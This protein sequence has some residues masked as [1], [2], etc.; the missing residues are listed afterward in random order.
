MWKRLQIPRKTH[1][2]LHN[3][4]EHPLAH[5]SLNWLLR[6][7]HE[8]QEEIETILRQIKYQTDFLFS[9]TAKSRKPKMAMQASTF[10]STSGSSTSSVNFRKLAHIENNQAINREDKF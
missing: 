1:K 6:Y 9:F 10:G 4:F 5:I 7:L 3:S 2:S 8:G